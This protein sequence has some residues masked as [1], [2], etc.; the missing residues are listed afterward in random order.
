MLFMLTCIDMTEE[1]EEEEEEE[2][3]AGTVY[4]LTTGM[5]GG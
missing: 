2:D 1:E 4:W 3:V 5:R